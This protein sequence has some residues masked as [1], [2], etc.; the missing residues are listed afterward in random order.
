MLVSKRINENSELFSKWKHAAPFIINENRIKRLKW[1]NVRLT[2]MKE[3][4]RQFFWS[5]ES[6]FVLRYNWASRVWR[7]KSEK[8]ESWVM[9][10]TVKHDQKIMVWSCF[11]S[12]GIGNLHLID[13]IMD[14]F[15]YH[16]ILET[17]MLPTGCWVTQNKIF[18]RTMTQNILQTFVNTSMLGII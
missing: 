2:W 6:P 3:Q 17:Q 4:L 12:L 9:R 10:E 15:Q 16:T 18:I 7:A 8:N 5:V 13:G 14:R 1:C 11:S